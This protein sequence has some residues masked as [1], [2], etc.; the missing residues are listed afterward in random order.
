MLPDD[1]EERPEDWAKIV[2]AFTMD[3]R[4]AVLERFGATFYSNVEECAD[5]PK[6]LAEGIEIGRQCECLLKKMEDDAPGG[7]L[8]RWLDGL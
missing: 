8:D 7:Y 4:C 2:M 3:E 5:V 6:S 1:P